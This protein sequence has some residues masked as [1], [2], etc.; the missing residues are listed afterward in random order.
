MKHH[1]VYV[2]LDVK[3]PSDAKITAVFEGLKPLGYSPAVGTSPAGRL[4]ATLTVPA[5]SVYEA[6]AA[7]RGRGAADCRAAAVR[8]DA[9]DGDE[10]DAVQGF[11]Q[12][13]DLVSVSQ[14]AEILQVSR[15]RVQQMIDAG[16]FVTAR[17]V[18]NATVLATS[19]VAGRVHSTALPH[20]AQ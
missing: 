1:A 10:H 8:I 11:D 15:Q 20:P 14:A 17:K 2:E 9:L 12:I 16:Q 13:P 6:T 19:E 7:R 4:D 3:Q 18:G 5:D